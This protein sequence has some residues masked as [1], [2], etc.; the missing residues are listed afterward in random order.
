[1]IFIKKVWDCPH[2]IIGALAGVGKYI[3]LLNVTFLIEFL[4]FIGIEFHSFAHDTETAFCHIDPESMCT[5]QP[6]LVIICDT[7]F[8]RSKLIFLTFESAET[9]RFYK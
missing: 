4:I 5:S 7:L 9:H 2:M 1:M 8:Q 6:F 3:R